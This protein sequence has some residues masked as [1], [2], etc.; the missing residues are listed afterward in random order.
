MKNAD[1]SAFG[2]PSFKQDGQQ[3]RETDMNYIESGQSGLTKRE[4]ISAMALQGLL[5]G[6]LGTAEI[7]TVVTASIRYADELLK[8]LEEK[9]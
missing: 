6:Q 3:C 2:I 9:K 7:K 4:Y 8:Q 5:A 1:A